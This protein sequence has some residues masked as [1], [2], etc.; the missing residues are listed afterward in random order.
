[1]SFGSKKSAST[2][3]TATFTNQP[4]TPSTITRTAGTAEA[5]DRVDSSSDPQS[6]LLSSTST[7]EEELK[8]RSVEPSPS[9]GMY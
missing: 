1:M 3:P 6:S 7:D 9:G 5:K 2:T 4:Q 8:R